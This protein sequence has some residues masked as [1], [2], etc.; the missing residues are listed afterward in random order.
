MQGESGVCPDA[1]RVERTYLREMPKAVRT[2]QAVAAGLAL[3]CSGCGASGADK[4]GG[5]SKPKPVV[6][7]LRN[8]DYPGRDTTEF[9][10]AVQ[11]L[12]G[13]SIRVV[14]QTKL[15]TSPD[16]E[17]LNLRDVRDGRVDMSKLAVRTLDTLGVKDLQALVAPLLIDSLALER[18]VL[19]SEVPG[20][21]LPAVGRLGVVAVAMLPAEVARPFGRTRA[22][23]APGDY[24]GAQIGFRRSNVAQ[25]TLQA[26]GAN[27]RP[28]MLRP[29]AMAG[30][31]GAELDTNGLAGNRYDRPGSTLT[32][33]IGFWARLQMIVISRKAYAS[34]APAQRRALQG[35]GRA[36][37]DAA[38]KRLDLESAQDTAV[39][40]RRGVQLVQASPA[41]IAAV[42]AAVRP[43][44]AALTRDAPTKAVIERIQTLKREAGDAPD[45]AP[46]CAAASTSGTEGPAGLQGTWATT[47][48]RAAGARA[49]AGRLELANPA[50][51]GRIRMTLRRGHFVY[52]NDSVHVVARGTYTVAGSVITYRQDTGQVYELQWSVYRDTLR[53]AKTSHSRE[54]TFAVAEPWRRVR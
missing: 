23:L 1:P 5:T 28:F 40:C 35:A 39:L 29:G 21:M 3:L 15:A 19:Q 20:H 24:R 13:G 54:A 18:T 26:L 53:Y 52:R 25:A 7:T 34:L 50:S 9:A 48:T 44:Y 12:S 32:A 2:L 38:I 10:D 8:S 16:F 31:D 6:L 27:T 49:G 17:R 43:V 14:E 33:N 22:L 51:W 30:L 36:S 47:V 45:V 37:L 11:R 42:R 4:A 46:P 41:D